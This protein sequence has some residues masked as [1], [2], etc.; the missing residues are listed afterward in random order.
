MTSSSAPDSSAPRIRPITWAILAWML[1]MFAA[2]FGAWQGSESKYGKLPEITVA[3]DRGSVS[4][5]PYL[6]ADL[7]DN[8]YTNPAP[9]FVIQNECLLTV[10]LGTELTNSQLSV[11]EL[12]EDGEREYMVSANTAGE[13]L[14]PVETADE[15]PIGGLVIKAVPRI[16]DANGEANALTGEW[17]VGFDY[18]N[19]AA[20]RDCLATSTAA[21][22]D[23]AKE[24][25]ELGIPH[26][27][28][29]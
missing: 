27:H 7:D 21:E 15:G 25:A 11:I 20:R 17:S 16:Y 18:A 13:L 1:I 19:A 22:T 3:T 14:I 5:L 23:S 26:P 4:A 12:R 6:A 10:R 24:L 9:E 29:H 28:K 8:T 2:I